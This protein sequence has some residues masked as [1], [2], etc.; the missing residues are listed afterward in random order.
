MENSRFKLVV[1]MAVV[2][3]TLPL[4]AQAQFTEDFEGTFPPT[5]WGLYQTGDPADP[6]WQQSDGSSGG[7]NQ[8]AHGG[9]YSAAHND[10]DLD[11]SAIS[12]LVL[13]QLTL[14]TGASLTFW[15]AT[16]FSTWN[17]YHG[18]WISAAS[19][20]PADGNCVELL[21]AGAGTEDTWT[22]TTVDLSA[23][24]G[25]SVYLA[26]R[27]EGDYADEWYIDDVTVT[28]VVPVELTS[29]SIE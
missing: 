2:A 15:E 19:G 16:N 1:L 21:D 3:I 23:Y 6:G 29:F 14:G 7:F 5:D 22:E 8:P 26:F 4:G 10:D 27:Y 25:Q 17:D 28:Q 13:P 24:D 18:I 9:T 12:W 20:D 11:T